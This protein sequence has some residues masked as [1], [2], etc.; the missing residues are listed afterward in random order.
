MISKQ[1]NIVE[2]KKLMDQINRWSCTNNFYKKILTLA[3]FLLV[4]NAN[5][6]WYKPI[7]SWLHEM[8][9]CCYVGVDL[10]KRADHYFISRL[11][12]ETPHSSSD[13]LYFTLL[14]AFTWTNYFKSN[15]LSPVRFLDKKFLC[16][17]S[18]LYSPWTKL[19]KAQLQFG[20]IILRQFQILS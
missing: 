19:F 9:A 11:R 1:T 15:S 6:A 8:A 3:V 16:P 20:K 4:P 2:V 18:L 17:I 14:L 7:L 13:L 10:A 12:D 5:H